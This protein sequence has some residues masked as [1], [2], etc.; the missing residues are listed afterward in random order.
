MEEY[1][2]SCCSIL[3]RVRSAAINAVTNRRSEVYHDMERDIKSVDYL[4]DFLSFGSPCS[5]NALEICGQ[6]EVLIA[7]HKTERIFRRI[8]A[9]T[10]MMK[11][12]TKKKLRHLQTRYRQEATT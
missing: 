9:N 3:F 2:A 7:M 8:K 1:T 5:K 11:A 6:L 12:S 4:D 10:L